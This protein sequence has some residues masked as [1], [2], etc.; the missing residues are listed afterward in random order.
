M[1]NKHQIIVVQL[2]ENNDLS[3]QKLFV[4][5]YKH[6]LDLDIRNKLAETSQIS[7][8]KLLGHKSILNGWYNIADT[9]D[10]VFMCYSFKDFNKIAKQ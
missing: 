6:L 4:N 7:H 1:N 2:G 8:S 3:D 9:F 10:D 5:R